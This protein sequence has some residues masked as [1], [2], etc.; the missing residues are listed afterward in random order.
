MT[1]KKIRTRWGLYLS[2]DRGFKQEAFY[3][4][5]ADAEYYLEEWNEEF[6]NCH[7]HIKEERAQWI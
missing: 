1:E 6:P 2:T 7:F 4:T 5:L 3:D